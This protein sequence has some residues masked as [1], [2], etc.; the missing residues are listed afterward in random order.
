MLVSSKVGWTGNS[1]ILAGH[2]TEIAIL[3]LPSPGTV[4]VSVNSS[5]GTVVKE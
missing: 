5:I 3:I 2:V 4:A 1:T